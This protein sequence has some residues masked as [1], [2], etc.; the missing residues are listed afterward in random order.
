MSYKDLPEYKELMSL[1]VVE[2]ITDYYNSKK[3]IIAFIPTG[4]DLDKPKPGDRK[5]V[6]Q[7]SG[8]IRYPEYEVNVKTGKTTWNM[9]GKII[10]KFP[11]GQPDFEEMGLR[12]LLA[13]FMKKLNLADNKEIY[14]R[15]ALVKAKFLIIRIFDDPKGSFSRKIIEKNLNDFEEKYSVRPAQAIVKLARDI[16]M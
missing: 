7:K 5:F 12:L 16:G 13:Y 15:R 9:N 2:D 14:H 6:I 11:A 10:D 3:P 1:N 8:Y 4:Q